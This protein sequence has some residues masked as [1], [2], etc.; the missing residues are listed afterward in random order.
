MVKFTLLAIGGI[1]GTISRYVLA[2]FIYGIFGTRFPHG[3]LVVNLLGC[4]LVGFFTAITENKFLLNPNLK[5]LL[6]IGFCGA[7]TTFSTFILETSNLIRDGETLRAFMNVLLSVSMGFIIFRIGF[8][9]A[10]LI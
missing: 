8:F 5:L 10:D 1:T 7:F 9:L 3:T 4:F 2:G 6:M